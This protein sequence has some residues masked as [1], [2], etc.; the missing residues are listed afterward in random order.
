MRDFEKPG[1]GDRDAGSLRARLRPLSLPVREVIARLKAA[2]RLIGSAAPHGETR[3][4][5][6]YRRVQGEKTVTIGGLV[7]VQGLAR[8]FPYTLHGVNVLYLVSSGL[9]QGAVALARA[10]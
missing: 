10:A 2:Y 8:V 7:K 4:F 5:Y 3:V 1:W 9:P 6:G